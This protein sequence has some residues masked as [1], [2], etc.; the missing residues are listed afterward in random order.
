MNYKFLAGVALCTTALLGVSCSKTK[1]LSDYPGAIIIQMNEGEKYS[2]F[3]T[4]DNL[5]GLINSDDQ[6]VIISPE[7]GNVKV[8][9][10]FVIAEW[11]GKEID[12]IFDEYRKK[13]GVED[14]KDLD[15]KQREKLLA[16]LDKHEFYD[17]RDSGIRPGDYKRL[18]NL[19]GKMLKDYAYNPIFSS[20][21][22]DAIAW[23]TDFNK[24]ADRNVSEIVFSDGSILDV[25]RFYRKDGELMYTL[26]GVDYPYMDAKPGK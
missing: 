21:N 18:F 10:N 4:E 14:I 13:A 20:G 19:E 2:V 5:R 3:E 17:V 6:T 12:D 25:D 24:K 11:S 8:V 1:T 15:K 22:P 9:G 26:D 7:Y 23:K 16:E